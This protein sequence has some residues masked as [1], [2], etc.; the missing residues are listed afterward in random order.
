MHNAPAVSYPVGRSRFQLFFLSTISVLGLSAAV[1]WIVQAQTPDWRQGVMLS[2]AVLTGLSAIW[3]WRHTPVG[4]LSWQGSSWDWVV[5]GDT[6]QVQLAVVVD[7]QIAMLLMLRANG[8]IDRW[9]WVQRDAS[10][11]RWWA[12]RR[13]VYQRLR[14][15]QDPLRDASRPAGSQA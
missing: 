14:A 10:P 7:L 15:D 5:S 2:G 12:L 11:V 4:Q 8:A 6:E 13:A 1:T 9:L 3:Q